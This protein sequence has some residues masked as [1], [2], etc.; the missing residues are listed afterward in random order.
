MPD[1]DFYILTKP[2]GESLAKLGS[3]EDEG[4]HS[5]ILSVISSLVRVSA[6]NF[7]RVTVDQLRDTQTMTSCLDKQWRAAK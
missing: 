4:D 5:A 6:A 7:S 3:G 2:G 1:V